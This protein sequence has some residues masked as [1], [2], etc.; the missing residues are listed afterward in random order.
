VRIN[1]APGF[2]LDLSWQVLKYLRFTGYL[3]EH[4]HSL[5]LPPGSLGITCPTAASCIAAPNAHFYSF[6]VRLSPT[7]PIGKRV[8]L[9]LTGGVGWGRVEYDRFTVAAIG[10]GTYTIPDRPESFFEIP[11]GLGGSVEL[12]PRWLSLRIELTG[13]FLPSQIGDA[14]GSTQATNTQGL[15]MNIGPMP[16]L[17]AYFLQTVGL[18]L[19]L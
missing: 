3:S 2:H 12:I 11:L 4:D 19:H 7:L 1:P 15:M 10:G 17:D 13:A 5:Q 8:R 18:S 6:G 14:L 9:W 16:R